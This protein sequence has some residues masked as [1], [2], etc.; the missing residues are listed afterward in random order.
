MPL[1]RGRSTTLSFK[2]DSFFNHVE[3]VI[4]TIYVGLEEYKL[5]VFI[6]YGRKIG[7]NCYKQG[8]ICQILI[9]PTK[10]IFGYEN[11]YF[12]SHIFSFQ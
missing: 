8:S 10:E 6:H 7:I 1:G 3:K 12:S 4:N 11:P 9:N 2:I 5:F